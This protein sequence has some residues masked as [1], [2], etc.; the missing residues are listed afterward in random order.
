MNES[1]VT[2]RETA[3]NGAASPPVVAPTNINQRMLVYLSAHTHA[4]TPDYEAGESAVGWGEIS[5]LNDV[6]YT[7]E[8]ASGAFNRLARL[9]KLHRDIKGMFLATLASNAPMCAAGIEM[10]ALDTWLRVQRSSLSNELIRAGVKRGASGSFRAGSTIGFTSVDGERSPIAKRTTAVERALDGG[11]TRLKIKIAPGRIS[12]AVSEIQEAVESCGRSTE[13]IEWVVDANGS[14]DESHIPELLALVDRRVSMIEQPFD[15][16]DHKAA[17]QL[18][19]M[20]REHNVLVS[21]DEA[22]RSIN[23]I[24]SLALDQAA[25][26]A[27]V[28]PACV[29]GLASA[30]KMLEWAHAVGFGVALGGMLESGLG[31]H[32]LA[33]I[34]DDTRFKVT[35]D[36]SPSSRWFAKDPF[37]D[38]EISNGMIKVPNCHSIAGDPDLGLLEAHTLERCVVEL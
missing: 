17:A 29:G 25:T 33:A 31:R 26:A 19:K 38:L 36:L 12:S 22:V 6:G 10:L 24:G 3:P 30:F 20:L 1:L 7:N 35:G 27:I 23:D 37:Q 9:P 18:V 34:A 2:A 11:V 5:A 15:P 21:A 16:S 28:K 8:S 4:V 14:L 13:E 32:S